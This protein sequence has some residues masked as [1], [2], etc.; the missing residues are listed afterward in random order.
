MTPV[1]GGHGRLHRG[2]DIQGV[3]R[4]RRQRAG[5]YLA[6]HAR[7]SE[8][9]AVRV[10]VVASR[11]VGGAVQRNRVKRLLREAARHTAFR[12]GVDVVLVGRRACVEA[13]LPAVH[14]EL[15]DLAGALDVLDRTPPAVQVGLPPLLPPLVGTR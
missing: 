1:E 10:A 5:R 6:V 13:G 4:S 11:R 12:P 2:A 14:R 15:T 7:P 3:L 8:I 9:D